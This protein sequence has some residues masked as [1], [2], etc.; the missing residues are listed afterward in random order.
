MNFAPVLSPNMT[1]ESNAPAHSSFRSRLH[2]II[3]EADTP[4][5]KAFD[6]GLIGCILLSVLLVILES[7]AELRKTYGS[8]MVSAEWFFTIAFTIEY[9]FRLIAVRRPVYYAT[10]FF[11]I[12]DL[13]A[14]VPTYLSVFVPG[15]QSLLVIRIFRLLRVFRIFKLAEYLGQ[16]HVLT[17]ALRASRPKIIVFLLAVS[18]TVVTMGALMYLVEGDKSGFTSIPIG[19]YWAIVTMTTVGFGDITPKTPLG[20][21]LA[22]LLMIVGY[23][24]IAVPTG[25]VTTELARASFPPPTTQACPNCSAQGHDAD[26]KFCKYCGSAL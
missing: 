17:T 24:I 14:I 26:A 25:I 9:F 1:L 15:T 16:A 8:A 7:V 10:S 18:A 6:V 2:Q 13:L 11:G 20:Q 21:A 22:S 23:G 3:F 5:G 12:V 19:I 4:A